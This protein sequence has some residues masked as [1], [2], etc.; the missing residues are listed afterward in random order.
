MSRLSGK[1]L[2]EPILRGGGGVSISAAVGG[3]CP[4]GGFLPGAGVRIGYHASRRTHSPYLAVG[5]GLVTSVEQFESDTPPPYALTVVRPA[6][7]PFVIAGYRWLLG[8]RRGSSLEI[9]AG[10]GYTWARQLQGYSGYSDGRISGV[11]HTRGTA[12][13][14]LDLRLGI[15]LGVGPAFTREPVQAPAVVPP[16]VAVRE[17][18]P[19]G[20]GRPA[21]AIVVAVADLDAQNLS[22]GDAAVVSDW[23]RGELIRRGRFTVVERQRVQKVLSEQTFQQ[24]GCTSQEC[25]VKL[26]KL[27]NADRMVVSFG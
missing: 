4:L 6:Y 3:V 7:G 27:L 15:R 13:F 22:Q 14:V 10:I 24:T 25:A 9:G 17:P 21:S 5:Y 1:D 11:S 16:P 8:S 2:S 23:L 19:S 18:S 12:D 26:G 20:P